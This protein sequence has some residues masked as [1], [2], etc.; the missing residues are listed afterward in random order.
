MKS[1]DLL[2]RIAV[3]M[4]TDLAILDALKAAA[5]AIQREREGE[6]G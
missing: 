3:A 1:L 4:N 5:E 2:D 6:N